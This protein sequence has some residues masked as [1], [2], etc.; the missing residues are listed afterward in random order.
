[1]AAPLFY[2]LG[3]F[4][5]I[6]CISQHLGC[7]APVVLGLSYLLKRAKSSWN[8]K[9]HMENL[10][11]KH[12]WK[13]RKLAIFL[14]AK[15]KANILIKQKRLSQFATAFRIYPIPSGKKFLRTFL[16]FWEAKIPFGPV[17]RVNQ[18]LRKTIG[19]AFAVPPAYGVIIK[20]SRVETLFNQ[21][22]AVR[23]HE[24]GSSFSS[25]N[26][27]SGTEVAGVG[28]ALHQ[29]GSL[30]SVHMV[31]SPVSNSAVV[32]EQ[33][34]GDAI[35]SVLSRRAEVIAVLSLFSSFTTRL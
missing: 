15:P 13:P 25:C 30:G 18:V 33:L 8:D 31:S 26:R 21:T 9:A 2:V 11:L 32:G 34:G 17:K 28:I 5:S 27:R 3:L 24:N 16:I 4:V 7:N 35:A 22:S 14:P 23:I 1:M 6:W 10:A 29:A 12:R 19:T 20:L